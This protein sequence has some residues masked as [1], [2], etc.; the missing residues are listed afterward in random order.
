MRRMQGG[1]VKQ[2][3]P[4]CSRLAKVGAFSY[5]DVLKYVS[6]SRKKNGEKIMTPLK[7]D[8]NQLRM[9]QNGRKIMP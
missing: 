7:N 5:G 6:L 8:T 9:T 2:Q 3:R 1:S 4:V